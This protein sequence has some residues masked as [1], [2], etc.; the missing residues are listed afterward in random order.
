MQL[1]DNLYI[2]LEIIG[3]G[4]KNFLKFSD[5]MDFRMVETA[6]ASLPYVY[7]KILL[8]DEK[9]KNSI[10]Q[11]NTLKVTV[12]NNIETADSFN[13]ELL[14]VETPKDPSDTGW[15][16]ELAGFIGS[17]SYMQEVRTKAY[18]GNSLFVVNEV[19]GEY[20]GKRRGTPEV[21]NYT[22]MTNSLNKSLQDYLGEKDLNTLNQSGTVSSNS[23]VGTALKDYINNVPGSANLRYV[24]S[25]FT[26]T[27]E[28]QVVWRQCNNTACYFVADTLLHADL[29]P[30]FP[31]FSFDRYLNFYIKDLSRMVKEGPTHVFTPLNPSETNEIR[32]FNSFNTESFKPMYNLYSGYNKI[33]EIYNAVEGIPLSTVIANEPVL[34]ST[35]E[36]DKALNMGNICSANNIQSSNVHKNYNIAFAYNTNKLVALSAIVGVLELHDKYYKDIHPTE[37]ISV[38]VYDDADPTLGG[39]YLIDTILTTAD[40]TSGGFRTYVYITRDNKNNVENYVPASQKQDWLRVRREWLDSIVS[41]VAGAKDI[42]AQ[43]MRIIDGRFLQELLS[44]VLSVKNSALRAF[45][46]AGVN[47]DFNSKSNLITSLIAEGNSLLNLFFDMIFPKEIAT[48]LRD[49]VIRERTPVGAV[50]NYVDLYVPVEVRSIVMAVVESLFGITDSLNSIA[51]DNGISVSAREGSIKVTE[52][53]SESAYVVEGQQRVDNIITRFENNTTGLTVPFPIIDISESQALLSEA[54]LE[55]FVAN[56]T[57]NKLNE[58]GYLGNDEELAEKFKNILLGNEPIDFDVINRINGYAGDILAYRFWGTYTSPEE[59]TSFFIKESFKDRYRT[60]PCT[61]LISATQNSKIFFA[62]PSFE[63]NLKFYVNSRRV[64]LNNFDIP[65][66]YSDMNG[67]P[68]YYTVYYTE[69]G[70]NSNSVLFE[71]KQGGMV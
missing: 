60:I 19:M 24:S 65:M 25:E 9:I 10:Q 18:W 37:L 50:S 70:Y 14:N 71:V 39:R 45:R 13:V 64:E 62:C 36:A 32:Y 16:V 47:I 68:L 11:T 30:S 56:E 17:Q 15:C 55:E 63:D 38:N 52:S 7:M 21:L 26:T 53:I 58:L 69:T 44:Y 49:Y 66:G 29:R 8:T 48:S 57:V 27:N 28:N 41:L 4:Y 40:F 42:Y 35:T 2:D 67:T 46:V 3:T 31:L 12:G 61:K 33:T 54:E 43:A 34:A 5:V 22:A 1:G 59:L 51:K 23:Q 20:F 6:G